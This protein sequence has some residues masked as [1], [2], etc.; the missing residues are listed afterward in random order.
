MRSTAD[1]MWASY[2]WNIYNASEIRSSV[3][4]TCK[5]TQ[6]LLGMND[7][8]PPKFVYGFIATGEVT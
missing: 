6:R 4:D 1:I 3:D 2:K 7:I 8:L 5:W